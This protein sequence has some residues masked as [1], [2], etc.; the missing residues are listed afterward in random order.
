MRI[1]IVDDSETVRFVIRK[2]LEG[3]GF[4]VF[5]AKN[6]EEA[7]QK[8][9]TVLP[10]VVT[11]D[12]EMP[13]KNGYEVCATIRA[14]EGEWQKG[15]RDLS[16]VPVIFVTANDTLEERGKGF[17]A[18][19]TNFITKPF[20]PGSVLKAV[21][22]I[23][24]EDKEMTGVTVLIVE[25]S[26]STRFV[27]KSTLMR[28]GVKVLEAVNGK[29]AWELLQKEGEHIDLVLTDYYMPE[30]G[31]EELCRKIRSQKEISELPVIFLTVAKEQ[32]SILNMFKAG[33]SDYLM[34]PFAEEELV[35][36]LKVHLREKIL[37][38]QL[39]SKIEELETVNSAQEEFLAVVSHDLRAPLSGIL[40]IGN[41]LLESTSLEERDLKLL[42]HHQESANFLLTFIDDL[43]GIGRLQS[44]NRELESL[45][46]DVLEIAEH[47]M[48]TLEHMAFPK[49]I[50]I[51]M[52]NGFDQIKPIIQG[53]KNAIIRI[54]NNLLSNAIKF[55]PKQGVVQMVLEPAESDQIAISVVDNGVGIPEDK[56][57]FLF[58]P[59]SKIN[60]PG[61]NGEK[62]SGLGLSI[63]KKLVEKQK[64][65]ISV[66]SEVERGSTFKILFPLSDRRKTGVKL[67]L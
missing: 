8:I 7:L 26:K 32:A 45:P 29:S 39:K 35:A 38:D 36:R 49:E 25:D 41:L 65:Q 1:L 15:G 24:P 30:I 17:K 47:C 44:E 46:V 27:L 16:E 4:E 60:Q 51:Q 9:F 5:D 54:F 33:A 19:G 2:E 10:D 42:Q 23:F 22:D 3:A 62:G 48:Q 11:L 21:K 61:T 43:L 12:I 34:K 53:D 50:D 14:G 57:Q 6:G 64:G 58:A 37:K 55:T 59:Y 66:T 31:G 56:F 40:G 67:E 20:A 13:V 52:E 63:V 28:S 18:G